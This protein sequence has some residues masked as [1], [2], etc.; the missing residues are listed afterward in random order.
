MS[1]NYTKD[2]Y[3]K[4]DMI[5]C[6]IMATRFRRDGDEKTADLIETLLRT[7]SAQQKL[8]NNC[9]ALIKAVE[10]LLYDEPTVDGQDRVSYA[11]AAIDKARGS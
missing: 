10:A 11:L 9:D 6:K 5:S 3:L 2:F 7:I 1:K 8:I 4:L